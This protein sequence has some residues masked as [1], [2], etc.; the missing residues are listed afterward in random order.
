MTNSKPS[1]VRVIL[2]S[3]WHADWITSDVERYDEIEAAAWRAAK[4]AID[5]NLQGNGPS[6]FVF[7]GDL[8]NPN[9]PRCWRAARLASQ[10]VRA[11]EAAHVPSIWLT[12]NHDV[13]EDG[14]GSHTL[15]PIDSKDSPWTYVA[16]RPM[17]WEPYPG[18][19][20]MLLPYVPRSLNYDP[21]LY[22]RQASEG[23]QIPKLCV[24]HLMVEGIGPGSE[25][26]DMARGR[27]VFFPL[28]TLRE[29]FPNCKLANGHYHTGQ[30]FKGIHIPGSLARL[31]L[32]EADNSPRFLEIEL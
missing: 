11:L 32:Q 30:I 15:M 10:I 28:Q 22:V 2:T 4:Y 29:K 20:L 14:H 26:K 16:D 21:A 1:K 8:A 6:V 27:D 9:P 13:L 3:D 31:T 18:C 25:T 19:P 23:S 5:S 17:V 24:G 12:G 7:A